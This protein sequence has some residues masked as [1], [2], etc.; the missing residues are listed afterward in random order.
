MRQAL[1]GWRRGWTLPAAWPRPA[2]RRAGGVERPRGS[3]AAG[4]GGDLEGLPVRLGHHRARPRSLPSG[5]VGRS[6]PAGAGRAGPGRCRVTC[7][8][9]PSW[10]SVSLLVGGGR[11]LADLTVY[12]LLS[13]KA[14]TPLHSDTP[15]P[16]AQAS[17]SS[18]RH[19]NLCPLVSKGLT[20]DFLSQPRP[21]LGLL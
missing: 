21:L 13:S 12:D 6:P 16:Q 18:G 11:Q 3:P 8:A 10:A 14:T 1:C 20:P 19:R 15:S 7:K 5:L 2:T 4:H 9:A 17:C